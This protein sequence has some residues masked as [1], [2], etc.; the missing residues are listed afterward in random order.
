[1]KRDGRQG[2]WTIWKREETLQELV[3]IPKLKRSLGRRKCNC[4][5]KY[6]IDHDIARGSVD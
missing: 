2:L 5:G 1:M 4:K 6:K 3:W